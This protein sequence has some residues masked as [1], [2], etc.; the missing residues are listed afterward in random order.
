MMRFLHFPQSYLTHPCQPGPQR[1][2][3]LLLLLMVSLLV[4]CAGPGYR[5]GYDRDLGRW[6][7]A[8]SRGNS[9]GMSTANTSGERLERGT[10]LTGVISW[11]GP[12]F[13]GKATASGEIFDEDD[14]TCAHRT[15]AFGTRLRVKLLTTGKSVEVVVNDRGPFVDD[16]LIDLSKGAAEEI[17]LIATGTGEAE[18]EI[19]E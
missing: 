19:L 16:R 13:D 10:R 12:G 5:G 14:R 2:A 11:Y 6:K 8:S 15:L 18:V 3:L 9:G 17:G 1:F 4:G 7:G